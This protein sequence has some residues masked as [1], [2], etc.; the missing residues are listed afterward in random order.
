MR[1]SEREAFEAA[2]RLVREAQERAEQAANEAARDVPPNGWA[3]DAAPPPN[4]AFGDLGALIKLENI[5]SMSAVQREQ[6]ADDN[7]DC[8]TLIKARKTRYC[9]KPRL[10]DLPA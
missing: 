3:S 8:V 10:A 6:F 1:E 4:A 7:T 2:E 5:G 9:V